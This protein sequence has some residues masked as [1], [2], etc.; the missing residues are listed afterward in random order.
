MADLRS[1]SDD[2]L[3]SH[4]DQRDRAS[5]MS[6]GNTETAASSQNGGAATA[7]GGPPA[8]NDTGSAPTSE[9]SRQVQEVLSSDVRRP[10]A[11]SPDHPNTDSGPDWCRNHA[12]PAQGEYCFRKGETESRHPFPA[13]MTAADGDSRNLHSFSRSDH[14]SKKATPPHSR[15]CPV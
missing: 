10:S 9:V 5:S 8:G 14:T 4:N 7:N 13:R 3:P 15:S 12:E 1:P 11:L 2:N 6:L